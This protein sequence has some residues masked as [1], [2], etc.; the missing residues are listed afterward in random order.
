MRYIVL[1]GAT[2]LAGGRFNRRRGPNG[3]LKSQIN[4]FG[5]EVVSP[6]RIYAV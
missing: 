4:I 2:G 3:K 6:M 5:K 1:G